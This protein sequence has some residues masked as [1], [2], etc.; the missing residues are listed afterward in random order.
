M[1]KDFTLLISGISDNDRAV[2]TLA[3]TELQQ[4]GR[5]LVFYRSRYTPPYETFKELKNLMLHVKDNGSLFEDNVVAID[6]SE[7]VGHESEEYFTIFLKYLHDQ[8]DRWQYI[9]TVGDCPHAK[10]QDFYLKLRLYLRGSIRKDETF[11]DAVHLKAYIQQMEVENDAAEKLSD[12][13]MQDFAKPVRGYEMLECIIEELN[14]REQG[15]RITVNTLTD[16]LRDEDSML[17][18]LMELSA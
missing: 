11:M 15:E 7:W 9:F 5:T 3:E 10:L 4:A 17:G 16:Y 14:E 18:M 6:L 8:R 12:I 2:R 1:A 13:L